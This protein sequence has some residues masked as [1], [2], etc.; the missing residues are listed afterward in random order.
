[1]AYFFHEKSINPLH[2]ANLN[3]VMSDISMAKQCDGQ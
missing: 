1:M 2:N 3:K